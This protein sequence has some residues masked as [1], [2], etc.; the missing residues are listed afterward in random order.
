MYCL[1]ILKFWETYLAWRWGEGGQW[2]MLKI[3]LK[4]CLNLPWAVHLQNSWQ[5]YKEAFICA[6]YGSERDLYDIKRFFI[7]SYNYGDRKLLDQIIIEEK[8]RYFLVFQKIHVVKRNSK[9]STI[10]M[11]TESW[12]LVRHMFG[13]GKSNQL[14]LDAK[15]SGRL[16]AD[17]I[18]DLVEKG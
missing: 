3:I 8:M 13:T 16:S 14:V 18:N 5:L 4:G 1:L 15:T 2:S 9:S 7:I 11:P 6:K 17:E 10:L 12:R